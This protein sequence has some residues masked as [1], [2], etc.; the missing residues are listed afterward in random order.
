MEGLLLLL[1]LYAI[2]GR[3]GL[4]VGVG[5]LIGVTVTLGVLLWRFG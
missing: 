5:F 3:K 4:A 1:L 2:C